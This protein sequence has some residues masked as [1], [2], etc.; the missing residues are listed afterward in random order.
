M[1]DLECFKLS[2]PLL[3]GGGPEEEGRLRL[4]V[5]FGEELGYSVDGWGVVALAHASRP[6]LAIAETDLPVYRPDDL[7][8][9]RVLL[10]RPADFAIVQSVV[11]VNEN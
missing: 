10:I 5:Y 11:R 4:R 6:S 7:V 3:S 8:R 9:V 1:P 2:I